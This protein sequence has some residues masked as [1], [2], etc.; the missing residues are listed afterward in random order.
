MRLGQIMPTYFFLPPATFPLHFSSVCLHTP[1]P[2]LQRLLSLNVSTSDLNNFKHRTLYSSLS[3]LIS[4]D[5]PTAPPLGNSHISPPPALKMDSVV[6]QTRLYWGRDTSGDLIKRTAN[7]TFTGDQGGSH[8]LRHCC[9]A[10]VDLFRRLVKLPAS[11]AGS[12]TDCRFADPQRAE[13]FCCVWWSIS[14]SHSPH[15]NL[16][17]TAVAKCCSQIK[18]L[19]CFE[20]PLNRCWFPRPTARQPLRQLKK[21]SFCLT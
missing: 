21:R 7:C 16:P 20:I 5:A 15:R 19:G 2:P 12:C 17:R 9:K 13:T 10:S 3:L 18:V 8:H 6:F 11:A 14:Y 1:P 4:V